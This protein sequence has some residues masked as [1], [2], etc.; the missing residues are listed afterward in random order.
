MKIFGISDLHLDSKKEKPMDVFG[1]NWED[2]DLRIFEDWHQ[3][4]GQ[5]D[6]VLMPGDISWA[7]SMKGAETDLRI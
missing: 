3:K 1:K 2:H 4:V 6:L 7:L 5:D